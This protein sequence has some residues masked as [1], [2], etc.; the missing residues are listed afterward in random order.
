[1]GCLPTAGAPVA[2]ADRGNF[3]LN[4]RGVAEKHHPLP[5]PTNRSKMPPPPP[6]QVA[7]SPPPR[8]ATFHFKEPNPGV[9]G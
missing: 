7:S 9:C 2:P 3:D 1:M 4:M 8:G 6:P 5:N